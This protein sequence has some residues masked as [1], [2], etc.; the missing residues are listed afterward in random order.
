MTLWAPRIAVIA[1]LFSAGCGG[2][3]PETPTPLPTPAPSP[4]PAPAPQPAPAPTPEPTPAPVPAPPASPTPAIANLTAVF[5]GKS[6]TRAADHL[7]GSA[8]VVTF[9]FT[10]G[11][12]DLSGGKV[13]LYRVYN[14]G[15]S[16]SHSSPIP[17]EVSLT[18]S[19]T[20][21]QIRIDNECPLYDNNQT[22][23]ETLTLYDAAGH[24]S[25][26][27]SASTTRPVGAP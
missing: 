24:Q 10:D 8:L 20:S 14:T 6:C 12:G 13:V 21:G 18:G 26:S 9:D 19:A 4:A 22:S 5:S 11:D 1:L 16:E 23:T 2:T 15:R 7:T 27:L 17:A 3:A 25:N